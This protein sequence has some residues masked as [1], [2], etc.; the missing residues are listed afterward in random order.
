MARRFLFAAVLAFVADGF[1]F[2]LD[3]LPSGVTST[4][5]AQ[6]PPGMPS[7][8]TSGLKSTSQKNEYP[9]ISAPDSLIRLSSGDQLR[10]RWW[11][12]GSGNLE[13]VVDTR[14]EIVVPDMGRIVARGRSFRDVRD[15]VEA[16]VK[17]RIKTNL[18]DLQIVQM[19][20]ATIRISG[21]VPRPGLFECTPGTHVSQALLMADFNINRAMDSLTADLPGLY[22][23]KDQ[24]ASLR[25]VLLLRGGRDSVYLDLVRAA[26]IG[27][28]TQDPYL[29]DGDA[30]RIEARKQIVSVVGG[31]RSGYIEAI[32][33]ESVERLLAAAGEA[34]SGQEVELMDLSGATRM[35]KASEAAVDPKLGGVRI[36]VKRQPKLPPV[37]WVV[38]EVERPGAH[39]YSAGM[40][41]GDAVRLAGGILGGED[42]GVVVGYKR[43]WNWLAAA[44]DRSLVENYQLPELKVAMIDYYNRMRGQYS[45]PDVKLQQ[46]DTVTVYKA[47]QVVWVSGKVNRPGFVRWKKGGDFN[48]YV[49]AAGG[50]APRAWENRTQVFDWQT[51]QTIGLD[52]PIR[53]GAAIVVP[54]EKY[55]SNEQ[56][57]SIAATTVSLLVAVTS[58]IVQVSK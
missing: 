18:V 23:S 21:L 28:D 58:L 31:F 37:V 9:A 55:I 6:L 15:S 49:S 25:R 17:R 11:G 54:E 2:S 33:G 16:L 36:S 29:F 4:S 26:R 40:T 43:S 3:D 22:Y 46:G 20:K 48:Y 24:I 39:P 38:G 13:L 30:V 35:A 19:K 42:S 45:D 53:P 7:L 34:N 52:Q 14:G 56:W 51:A 32:P 47:E 57:F 27:D 44:R 12:I 41:S 1:A 50:F 8:P 10:L 5:E